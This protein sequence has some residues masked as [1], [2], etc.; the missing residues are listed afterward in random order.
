M[1][2]L[3]SA[4]Y[5]NS[6]QIVRNVDLMHPFVGIARKVCHNIQ[7]ICFIHNCM[8]LCRAE[9]HSRPQGPQ[10]KPLDIL[11]CIAIFSLFVLHEILALSSYHVWQFI[12]GFVAFCASIYSNQAIMSGAWEV[13]RHYRWNRSVGGTSNMQHCGNHAENEP[14]AVEH[15]EHDSQALL[16]PRLIQPY[17]GE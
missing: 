9:M 14:G 12:M 15:E 16:C 6:K 3:N 8:F 4:N 17:Q 11:F 10:G 1:C 13:I 5:L 2:P 7:S